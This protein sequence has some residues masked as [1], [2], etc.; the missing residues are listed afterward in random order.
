MI[1][2][3]TVKAGRLADYEK[4]SVTGL[5]FELSGDSIKSVKLQTSIGPLEVMFEA[6]SVTAYEPAM[7]KLFR[8][9]VTDSRGQVPDFHKDFDD[10]YDRDGWLT[11]FDDEN[12]RF[13]VAASDFEEPA[14]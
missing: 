2:K 13:S 9:T 8:A 1:R 12:Q 3:Q 10:K 5:I 11:S 6:Y 4:A 7:R 14:I